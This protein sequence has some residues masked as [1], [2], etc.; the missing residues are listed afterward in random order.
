MQD[1]N[2]FAN[3]LFEK[4]EGASPDVAR[5]IRNTFGGTLVNQIISRETDYRSESTEPFHSITLT[6]QNKP[7]LEESLASLIEGDLLSGDNKYQLPDGNKVL[8]YQGFMRTSGSPWYG[9]V[10]SLSSLLSF[11]PQV[12][13]MKRQCIRELPPHLILHLKRF[14]FDFDTLRRKKL[15]DFCEIPFRLN[16][17]PYTEEGIL[18]KEA[19]EASDVSLITR[20][21][22]PPPVMTFYSICCWVVSCCV[23][24]C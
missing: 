8:L 20:G 17:K 3:M 24:C 11:A 1:V 4:L 21:H 16:M 15:N 13:A 19:E 9:P 5:L 6:I 14:E 10:L 2:E 7:N 12:D 23:L 22:E 18:A